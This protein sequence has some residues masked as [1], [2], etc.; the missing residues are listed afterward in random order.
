MLQIPDICF[1]INLFHLP[2]FCQGKIYQ[3]KMAVQQAIFS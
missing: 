2:L 3:T 1:A